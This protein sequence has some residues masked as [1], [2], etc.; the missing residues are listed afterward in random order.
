LVLDG[1]EI[2]GQILVGVTGKIGSPDVRRKKATG[3]RFQ[4]SAQ[5]KMSGRSTGTNK[6]KF[7]TV[8]SL[9]IC[10]LAMSFNVQAQTINWQGYTWTIKSGAGL[11][12][13]PNNW[14]LTNC[15][16][17]AN[18]YLHLVITPD[19]SSPNGWDCAELYTT[20]AIGFGTY[21]WQIEA[22]TDQLDP[23]V[24]LG[25][26][27]YGPPALGPDGSNEIDIE[28]SRW[29]NPTGTDGGFTVYPDSGTTIISHKFT[30]NLGGTYTTSRF[31]WGTK[32]I[33]FWLMGG[34]QPVEATQNVMATWNYTPTNQ[35]VTIP[36][37]AMPLHI[38]L[39]LDKG[40]IPS[41]GQPV[42]VIIH[43]FTKI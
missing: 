22:R 34:F 29:G 26:F 18:G 32:G 43:S 21:Q 20:N 40:H 13:G 33:Q 37:N 41:N 15:F 8:L 4:K 30:F 25:L 24:V 35:L 38:N 1:Y 39:W 42:E 31:K 9:A 11:G 36:Q 27:P 7:P 17:D 14:N 6:I 16:V 2:G 28:Y 12:P 19:A 3:A 5:S 10:A 23:W